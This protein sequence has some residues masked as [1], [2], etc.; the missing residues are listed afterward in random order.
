MA[1]YWTSRQ[2]AARLDVT[3]TERHMSIAADFISQLSYE[4]PATRKLLARVPTER[5]PRKPHPKSWRSDIWRSW[6]HAAPE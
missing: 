2:I 6:W 5:G 4:L 3:A 1:R